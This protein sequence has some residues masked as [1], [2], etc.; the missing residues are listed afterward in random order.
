MSD[1]RIEKIRKRVSGDRSD[2]GERNDNVLHDQVREHA[3]DQSRDDGMT[4]KESDV[5]RNQVVNRRD[6]KRNDEMKP[7]PEKGRVP[8]PCCRSLGSQKSRRHALP[9]PLK[10]RS[11]VESEVKRCVKEIEYSDRKTAE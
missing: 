3:E 1:H 2:R 7:D 6:T 8:T 9:H 10:R 11:A 5:S 4:D